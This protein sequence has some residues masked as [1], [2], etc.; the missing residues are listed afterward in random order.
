M[1]YLQKEKARLESELQAAAAELTRLTAQLETQQQAVGAAQTRV[2]IAQTNLAAAQAQIPV[3][4]AAAGA[5]DQRVAELNQQI[6]AHAE[7]EP[8]EDFESP[9][10]GR[11][12]QHN[13]AWDVWK[14]DQ[15]DLEKQRNQAQARATTAHTN[16]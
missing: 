3:L 10:P 4:E 14:Q 16:L 12:T 13:P 1:P 15:E 7:S 2:S 9:I 11:P 5:A 6:S 8:I